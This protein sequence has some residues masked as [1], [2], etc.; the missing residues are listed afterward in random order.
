[1]ALSRLLDTALPKQSL[2]RRTGNL[3]CGV[4]YFQ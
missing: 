2:E 4:S 1:M 3:T